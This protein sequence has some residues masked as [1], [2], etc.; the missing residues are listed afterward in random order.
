[1]DCRTTRCGALVALS[2][3]LHLSPMLAGAT[4]FQPSDEI[5]PPIATET[6]PTS[7]AKDD[8]LLE[9][10][11]P[12]PRAS[13]TGLSNHDAGGEQ[14]LPA[15][16]A[17]TTKPWVGAK[18]NNARPEIVSVVRKSPA[19]FA[20]LIPGDLLV[21]VQSQSV[22]TTAEVLKRLASQ[23]PGTPLKLK[24]IRR[25]KRY[26]ATLTLGSFYDRDAMATA[27]P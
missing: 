26:S 14:E 22:R 9:Q 3:S 5:P 15:P 13:A 23:H 12:A 7:I 11:L 24:L 25:G 17:S 8:V 20:G 10:E 16:L 19:Y 21:S 18:L 27:R 4:P 6:I 1:M 2:L